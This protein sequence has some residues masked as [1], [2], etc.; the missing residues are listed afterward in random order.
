MAN[1][2]PYAGFWQ[3]PAPVPGPVQPL[4]PSPPT[5]FAP[6][7]RY[8][9]LP[10]L[11]LPQFNNRATG[12]ST[13]PYS[14][15]QPS[16]K[17]PKFVLRDDDLISDL[18]RWFEAMLSTTPT[19]SVNQQPGPIRLWMTPPACA[20]CWD[21]IETHAMAPCRNEG[22]VEAYATNIISLISCLIQGIWPDRRLAEWPVTLQH[23]QQGD[24]HITVGMRYQLFGSNRNHLM[25]LYAIAG[26]WKTQTV[27]G[28]HLGTLPDAE[29]L[30]KE[31][32]VSRAA[33]L[34]KVVLFLGFLFPTA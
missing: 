25:G 16:G 18:G 9:H 1:P 5:P 21:A 13:A 4:P 19:I 22:W 2:L 20:H 24:R 14:N 17:A 3:P 32:A 33:I 30:P 8:G 15:N 31:D 10:R 27:A 34:K 7:Y 11:R 28:V 26:E 29:I 12:K 6:G 23:S